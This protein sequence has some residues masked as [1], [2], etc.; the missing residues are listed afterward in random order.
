MP[1]RSRDSAVWP[2]FAR[3][4]RCVVNQKARRISKSKIFGSPGV[5]GLRTFRFYKK[6]CQEKKLPRELEAAKSFGIQP[7]FCC[8]GAFEAYAYACAIWLRN[9]EI[10]R[11]QDHK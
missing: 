2:V 11:C 6:R 4:S 1:E 10:F 8:A 9:G 7:L 3:K 5:C